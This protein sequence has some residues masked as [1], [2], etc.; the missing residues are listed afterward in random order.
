MPQIYPS[1]AVSEYKYSKYTVQY[2]IR[3]YWNVCTIGAS[4][5]CTSHY[6]GYRHVYLYLVY[7]PMIYLEYFISLTG[8]FSV[9]CL[10]LVVETIIIIIIIII[11][12]SFA[13]RQCA[14]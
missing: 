10:N 9:S 12:I 7:Q 6:Y 3:M 5:Y 14:A 8:N 13:I 4:T 1:T 11:I 2:L